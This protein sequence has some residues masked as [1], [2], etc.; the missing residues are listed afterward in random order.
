[1]VRGSQKYDVCGLGGGGGR[2]GGVGGRKVA[3]RVSD[4]RDVCV[5]KTSGL[6]GEGRWM[7]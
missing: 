2:R 6:P 5:H 4:K 3:S 1:M 7:G